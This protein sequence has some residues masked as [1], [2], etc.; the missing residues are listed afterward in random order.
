MVAPNFT[1]MFKQVITKGDRR[2]IAIS[3]RP[4]L[5]AAVNDGGRAALFVRVSLASGQFVTDGRG[6]TVAVTRSG[7]DDY[8]QITAKERGVS[9]LFL[10]LVEYVFAR[11]TSV[12]TS[13]EAAE[14]LVQAVED[15]RR[16]V[17]KKSGRLSEELIRGTFAEMMFLG[18]LVEVGMDSDEAL[19][20]WRGPWA[21]AGIG[22][23]D[24]TF[25]DGRGIEVK[26][27]RH[28]LKTVRVSSPQQL[29]P[30]EQSLDLIV[31][32]VEE[33]PTAATHAK[34]F[35]ELARSLGLKFKAAGPSVFEKWTTALEVLSLDVHDEW[36]DRYR[37]IPGAWRRYQVDDRFPRL[38]VANLPA[39]IVDIRYSIDL[40]RLTA[41]AAPY[42][43]LFEEMGLS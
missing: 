5:I 37:F 20:A 18:S 7:S 4:C 38:D 29:V 16:F 22:T 21:K 25:P 28:P 9:P 8:V 10:S 36:Y 1:S 35:R 2:M 42:D 26:S 27:S 30:S 23:H 43:G 13:A 12:N 15:Y 14:E 17:G 6:F 24:F 19:T 32:P 40:H 39:G 41:L 33:A 11:V 34:S 3:Q 31:L